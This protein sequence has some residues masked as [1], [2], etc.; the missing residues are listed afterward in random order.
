MLSSSTAQ[1][2]IQ[3]RLAVWVL[4]TCEELCETSSLGAE[5]VAEYISRPCSLHAGG[6]AAALG[7]A[8][9]DTRLLRRARRQ[10]PEMRRVGREIMEL[11]GSTTPQQEW[12]AQG[13][14]QQATRSR[15]HAAGNSQQATRSRQHAAGTSQQATRNRQHAA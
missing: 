5:Y 3:P 15:Q 13:N 10:Q 4:Q 14:T 7:Q 8:V 9:Q 12:R 1:S 6:T 11:C 2:H